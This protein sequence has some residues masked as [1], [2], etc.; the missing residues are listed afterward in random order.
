MRSNRWSG[1]LL[2]MSGVAAGA[3][4]LGWLARRAARHGIEPTIARAKL[5]PPHPSDD[6]V[7]RA[8]SAARARRSSGFEPSWSSERHL[9]ARPRET[10]ALSESADDY[11]ALSPEEL[12][13]AFLV[14]ATEGVSD[15]PPDSTAEMVGFQIFEPGEPSDGPD[16]PVES[17]P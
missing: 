7:G 10:Y 8:V 2:V 3:L 15:A 1:W 4:A 6:D 12:G 11:D 17:K 5:S 14:G 13:V 16:A 9:T